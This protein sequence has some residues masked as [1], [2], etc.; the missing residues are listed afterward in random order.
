[1]TVIGLMGRPGVGK[2]EIFALL[3][4]AKPDPNLFLSPSVKPQLAMAKVPDVRVD[5][6]SALFNPHRTINATIELADLPGFNPSED[7]K[8]ITAV[9]ENLRRCDG[10]AIVAGL[11]NPELRSS[12]PNAVA[13]LVEEL[14]LLDLIALEKNLPKIQKTASSSKDPAQKR[15]V[16]VLERCEK[17]LN[18]TLPLRSLDLSPEDEKLTREYA[19]FSIKPLL[20][21]ANL[22]EEHLT[23]APS[24]LDKLTSWCA[25]QNIELLQLSARVERE[26]TEL[27]E[28]ERME[29]MQE[30]GL[31][32]SGINRFAN[33][34]YQALGLQSFFTVGEDEVRAWSV[35]KGAT[36]VEAAGTIHTDLAR[37]FIRAEV[38]PCDD[39]LEHSTIDACKKAGKFRLEGK[40]YIVKDG[41]IVHIRFNV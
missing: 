20:V 10:L 5:K 28:Q 30:Y 35:R 38:I 15:K 11:F 21:V 3:T 34:C 18:E 1:M 26:L 4:S 2:S 25:E 9:M 32:D 37:G 23:A 41:E 33:A 7:K 36:A 13:D 12:I 14:I 31:T 16:E 24:E 29:Y 8:I 17:H 22:A 39:I 27:S 40:E 19:F 6:L